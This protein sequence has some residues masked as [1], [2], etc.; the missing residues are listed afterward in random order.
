MSTWILQPR[1]PLLTR[2]G[3]PFGADPGSRA[4]SLP[5]P[6]P[7]VLAGAF[8]SRLGPDADGQYA[9]TLARGL[10]GPFL[11][12]LDAQGEIGRYGL[13]A[14][15]DAILF[16]E[17]GP[18]RIEPLLPAEPPAGVLTDLDDLLPL[19]IAPGAPEKPAPGAPAF[20]SWESCLEWLRKPARGNWSSAWSFEG[21]APEGR[22][23]VSI[24]S[25]RLTA[26]EGALFSTEGRRYEAGRGSGARSL[27]LAIAP[28][29]EAG[30]ADGWGTLGGERRLARWAKVGKALPELPGDLLE[31]IVRH[32][33]C[34]VMLLTPAMF[35]GG[36]RPAW[37]LGER[38]GV[39]PSLVA[40]AVRRPDTVSGWNLATRQ[41]KPT[42]RLAPA[43]SVYFVS[44]EGDEAAI[45]AWIQ[46]LWW[47][48]VSDDEQDRRDGFGVV[49]LGVWNRAGQAGGTK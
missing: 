15:A 5:V 2:D 35:A 37:L 42:R 3:R 39:K 25:D 6:P 9:Y 19:A 36:F 48:A 27:A 17:R 7:S 40:A 29:D 21:P 10:R 23:H 41:R 45:R 44:L 20:W 26:H 38:E 34:R 4:R 13:P 46:A 1:D 22:T 31:A 11:V 18:E 14:P 16:G 30:L 28:D 33:A 32:K 8:R 43:G 49:A 24:A 47:R 12:E